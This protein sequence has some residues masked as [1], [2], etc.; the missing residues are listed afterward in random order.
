VEVKVQSLD[1]HVKAQPSLGPTLVKIDVE[2]Y[3]ARVLD[4]AL[5]LLSRSPQPAI[6]IETGDR[7]ADCIGESARSVLER[8]FSVGYA[9]Y[10]IPSDGGL[11]QESLAGV[12]GELRNY[13]CVHPRA[14]TLCGRIQALIPSGPAYSS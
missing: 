6:I 1:E 12:C 7:L 2:G 5:R 3:E 14:S 8:L 9:V 13:L 11:I 10:Q 4:G